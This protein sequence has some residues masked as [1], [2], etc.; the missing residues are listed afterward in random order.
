MQQEQHEWS[1]QNY[2]IY[3]I[4]EL[5]PSAPLLWFQRTEMRRSWGFIQNKCDL[6]I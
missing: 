2:T 1:A 4:Y 3:A 5:A 6:N